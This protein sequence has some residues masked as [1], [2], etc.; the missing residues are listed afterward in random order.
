MSS[1]EFV[2]GGVNAICTWVLHEFPISNSRWSRADYSKRT[3]PIGCVHKGL[4]IFSS[5]LKPANLFR[6]GSR[7]RGPA[8]PRTVS[9]RWSMAIGSYI[10]R[11]GRYT[12][13]HLLFRMNYFMFVYIKKSFL[14]GNSVKSYFQIHVH[15]NVIS[16]GLQY[17]KCLNKLFRKAS[18][19]KS[20]TSCVCLS[21]SSDGYIYIYIAMYM[22]I[23]NGGWNYRYK[24]RHAEWYYFLCWGSKLYQF[25][26]SCFIYVL[27][28]HIW[29]CIISARHQ[30]KKF[31]SIIIDRRI[32]MI[33][34]YW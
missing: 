10:R 11:P 23:G 32:R 12:M 22:C 24:L 17:F 15:W 1:L 13:I 18:E 29:Y 34:V 33:H 9:G 16:V 7:W 30:K 26:S 19:N 6:S 28:T 27:L 20:Y 5:E 31:S 25:N 2:D 8:Y 4:V 3:K 14:A 21:I